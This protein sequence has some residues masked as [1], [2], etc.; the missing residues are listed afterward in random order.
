MPPAKSMV[1]VA[2]AGSHKSE[3]RYNQG[4]QETV[5]NHEARKRS[6]ALVA[7]KFQMALDVSK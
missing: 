7:L 3:T 1:Q 2:E 6:S 5:R 4:K